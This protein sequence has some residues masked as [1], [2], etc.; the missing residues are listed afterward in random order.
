SNEL[1]H[2]RALIAK[3]CELETEPDGIE[4]D[5]QSI[6]VARINEDAEYEGVRVRFHATLAR[7]RIQ[8]QID[9]GFGDVVTPAAIEIEYPTL[10]E[11]PAPVLQIGR[12]SCRE[13]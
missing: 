1:E 10:L 11:F 3:V 4:F 8:M 2:I 7:A 12:A 6:K 9:I 13:S 5:A